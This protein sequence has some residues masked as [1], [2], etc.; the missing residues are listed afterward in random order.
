MF[1]RKNKKE[2]KVDLLQM[3]NVE[4]AKFIREVRKALQDSLVERKLWNSLL[5]A[6]NIEVNGNIVY[7][8]NAQLN[9]LNWN[10]I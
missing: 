2:K 10:R 9:G 1:T 6:E 4:R 7:N 5:S 8:G 3:T